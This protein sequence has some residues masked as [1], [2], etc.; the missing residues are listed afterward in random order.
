MN[1]GI[2][3]TRM[4]SVRTLLRPLTQNATK[5]AFFL[6]I[7]MPCSVMAQPPDMGGR[8]DR[9][10]RGGGDRG[11]D[12]GGRGGE[13]GGRSRFGMSFG[14]GMGGSPFGGGMGGSPFGGGMGGSPFGGG[15]GGPMGGG[16]GGFDPSAMLARFDRNGNKMLDPDETQGPAGFFLQRM[17]QSNPKIDLSK[18]IPLETIAGEFDRMRQER[19]GMGGES[20]GGAPTDQEPTGPKPL[21]PT[22]GIP[23]TLGTVPG[24]GTQSGGEAPVEVTTRDLREAEDRMGRYDRNADGF[25]SAEEIGGGRWGDDPMQ[26]DRNRDGKLSKEELAVRYAKRRIAEEQQAQSPDQ[27]NGGGD[28]RGGRGSMMFMGGPGGM[29]GAPSGMMGDSGGGDRGGDQGSQG[30]GQEGEKARP[31]SLRQMT[32]R[33]KIDKETGKPDWFNRDDKDADGQVAMNEFASSWDETT[34]SDFAKFDLN[35]DGFIT[36]VEVRKAIA[37]GA[38]RSGG[39]SRSGASTASSSRRDSRSSTET[40]TPSASP[41]TPSG[42]DSKPAET[43]AS[44][45]QEST[46]T[47]TATPAPAPASSGAVDP[48]KLKWA[49]KQIGKYDKNKDGALTPNEYS[50]MPIP[51]KN[52]FDLDGDGRITA[53]EYAISRK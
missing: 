41:T 50:E 35:T 10:D 2:I 28:Q 47:P 30:S 7:A 8:W 45:P 23:T 4:L 12:R 19:M 49:E 21:V 39:S 31:R 40:A 17:A 6:A 48:V 20:F 32:T 29:M 15:M 22:F 14:G 46:P 37:N 11:G 25:L 42:S 53:E 43:V 3:K 38:S 24:F 9:G 44:A 27:N 5:V 13:E 52:E 1:T 26:F 51:P 16:M 36:T 18:P 34:I 33:E